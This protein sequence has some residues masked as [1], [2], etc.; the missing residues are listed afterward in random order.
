MDV[1][2]FPKM[3]RTHNKSRLCDV[4]FWVGRKPDLWLIAVIVMSLWNQEIVL[5]S[6]GAQIAWHSP[7]LSQFY[8]TAGHDWIRQP[9]FGRMMGL[10][11]RS[12]MK[13]FSCVR[14]V[15][16]LLCRHQ[17]HSSLYTFCADCCC[18]CR[19]YARRLFVGSL[20]YIYVRSAEE[21]H[22]L[23]N[24]DQVNITTPW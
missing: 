5:K 13:N 20:G 1:L 9:I 11:L 6:S 2:L 23:M 8:Q 14:T 15:C 21:G 12:I 19:M 3:A 7:S 4:A 18:C 24:Q 17:R 22:R 16:Y 10:I